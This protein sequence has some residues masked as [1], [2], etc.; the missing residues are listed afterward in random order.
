MAEN[1]K[2]TAELPKFSYPD[3]A[4]NTCMSAEVNPTDFEMQHQ[5]RQQG[6]SPCI[7]VIENQGSDQSASAPFECEVG[8]GRN[9][10]RNRLCQIAVVERHRGLGTVANAFVSGFGYNVDCAVASTVAHDSHHIIVVGTNHKDMAQAANVLSEIGGG[11]VVISNGKELARV[12]LPIAGLM[13]DEAAEIVAAKTAKMVAAMKACGCNLN[14]VHAHSCSH[15]SSS[16][17]CA[18]PTWD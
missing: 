18:F 14:S 1:G 6:R 5:R 8:S 10:S 7:G 11:V 3:T 2:L 16:R 4:K 12:E 17:N 15:S 13:S 9:G